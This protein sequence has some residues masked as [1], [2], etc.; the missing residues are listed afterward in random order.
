MFFFLP[1]RFPWAVQRR[2]FMRFVTSPS[3]VSQVVTSK[4]QWHLNAFNR[5]LGSLSVSN[6]AKT[7]ERRRKHICEEWM[8]RDK[9]RK[10]VQ[11]EKHC[12][13]SR[14]R[15][16]EQGVKRGWGV[17]DGKV[18]G[19]QRH[20]QWRTWWD[21]GRNEGV[22]MDRGGWRDMVREEG[23]EISRTKESEEEKDQDPFPFFFT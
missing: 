18:D 23:R 3:L 7:R 16:Q 9:E 17:V 6:T 21:S 22:E 20:R 1:W 19:G 2:A 12:K 15:L 10:E 5:R 14:W 11:K 4:P 13:R 8:K